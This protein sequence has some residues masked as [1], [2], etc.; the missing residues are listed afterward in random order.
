[1]GVF[2]CYFVSKLQRHRCPTFG[3]LRFRTNNAQTDSYIFT[4]IDCLTWWLG[5]RDCK[6]NSALILQQ[7]SAA[8][9]FCK[10][11]YCIR[12]NCNI[13]I[14]HSFFG[15]VV[16]WGTAL[17]VQKSRVR[18]PALPEAMGLERSPL[19]L[20]STNDELLGRK[21]SG[22]DLEIREYGRRE[23]SRWPRG[24][25]Y[26]QKLLLTSATSGGPSAGIVRSRTQATE[27]G[28]V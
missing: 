24:T 18:F 22:S 8:I 5:R 11:L 20:V 1:M 17:Q 28:L 12:T 3:A 26:P 14:K 10:S 9:G 19:S 16:G 25:L 13:L 2:A 15:R 4:Y 6:S 23:P 27:Y 21:S 7:I